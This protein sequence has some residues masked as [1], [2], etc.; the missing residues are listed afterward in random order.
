[1]SLTYLVLV[2]LTD[3]IVTRHDQS[4][5]DFWDFWVDQKEFSDVVQLNL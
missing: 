1:M 4:E 2:L 5:M 3:P